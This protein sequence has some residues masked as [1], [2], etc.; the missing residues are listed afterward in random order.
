ME[1]GVAEAGEWRALENPR[2]ALI[3]Q[4]VGLAIMGV[5][6]WG[7]MLFWQVVPRVHAGFRTEGIISGG[8]V[9]LWVTVAIVGSTLAVLAH[10][11]VH[12]LVGWLIGA[13]P[14]FGYHAALVAPY[15]TFGDCWLTRWQYVAVALAPFFVIT[16]LLGL[17]TLAL[18]RLAW[19]L[20]FALAIHAGGCVGD[21]WMVAAMLRMPADTQ[22]Q[23]TGVGF[24]WRRVST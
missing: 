8:T 13:R 24:R 23:D 9:V 22:F 21:F 4:F 20:T 11:G 15:C 12:G 17:V 2:G 10:E 6:G 1:D 18:P 7:A 3:A 14:R 5:A 19:P 16:L